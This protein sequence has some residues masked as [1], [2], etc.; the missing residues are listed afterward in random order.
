M[1]LHHAIAVVTR[2]ADAAEVAG[3]EGRG[4]AA[5]ADPEREGT[6]QARTG[7]EPARMARGARA[8]VGAGAVVAAELPSARVRPHLRLRGAPATTPNAV[9]A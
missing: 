7:A 4:F 1:L 3:T 9:T 8:V 2:P 5:G 6:R